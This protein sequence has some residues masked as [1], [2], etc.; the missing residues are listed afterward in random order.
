MKAKSI[1]KEQKP[2]TNE[3]LPAQS[4]IGNTG[5][6]YQDEV[7]KRIEEQTTILNSTIDGK[8][9]ELDDKTPR[10]S[11]KDRLESQKCLFSPFAYHRYTR[12][13][14]EVLKDGSHNLV[15]R[16]RYCHNM[17]NVRI[18]FE[19]RDGRYVAIKET[20]PVEDANPSI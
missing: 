19:L 4:S 16:C 1:E 13:L 17:I 11:K 7:S 18:T 6:T 12:S 10:L 14:R 5:T 9:V 15:M 3:I 2:A 20:I 8:K